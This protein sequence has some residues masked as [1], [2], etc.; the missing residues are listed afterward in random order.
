MATKQLWCWSGLN[1]EGELLQGSSWENKRHEVLLALQQQQIHLISLKRHAVRP[2]LWQGQHCGEIMRQ[3]ATLLQAGLTLPE[4]LLLL[5]QQQPS[6]QWQALLHALAGKLEQGESFSAAMAQWPDVF[7]PLYLAMVQTGE[8]NGNLDEC[9]FK[10]ASQQKAQ[11]LLARKVKKALRYP[12]IILSLALVVVLAMVYLVLPEFAAIYQTFNTPLPALTRG[13]M[14]FADMVQRFGV[15]LLV[16]G[17]AGC[18]IV[19]GLR[20]HEGWLCYRQRALLASPQIG[21]LVRG[22]R[23]SQIFTVLALTQR[24]GIAF[25]QGLESVGNTLTCPW[26]RDKIRAVHLDVSQGKAISAALSASGMFTPLCIQLVRTG[27]ASGALD[28]MLQNLAHHHSEQTSHHADNLAS[29]LEPLLL[30]VT[31]IIIGTLVIAM[32]LP[33]FHLGDAMSSVG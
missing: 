25:L 1:T 13:V 3:L 8:L 18:G 14:A 2:A 6:M 30:V 5:A 23:L 26:W 28:T 22:Q 32:Y 9:C 19:G 12:L 24:S 21:Q 7:P 31:G 20:H 15:V 27:E 29:L 4:S 11:L 33:I 10:L 17:I 16:M